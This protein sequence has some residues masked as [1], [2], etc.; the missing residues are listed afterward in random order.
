MGLAPRPRLQNSN[1]HYRSAARPW[2]SL[3]GLGLENGL[4]PPLRRIGSHGGRKQRSGDKP[5][6]RPSRT[7]AENRAP[8]RRHRRRPVRVCDGLA[9]RNAIPEVSTLAANVTFDAY[10]RLSPRP[11]GDAPVRVV[12]IDEASLAAF[13]QWP[14]PRTRIAAMVERLAGLG[15]AA[16]AF[17][18]LFVEPDQTSPLELVEALPVAS[19]KDRERLT[20]LVAPLPDHDQTLAKALEAAPTVLGFA[21]SATPN[22][23]RP[24]ARSGIAF[25]GTDPAVIVPAFVGAVPPLL[26][27]ENA[28]R[29]IG[30]VSLSRNDASGVVRRVPMLFSDGERTYPSLVAEALR[31][32]RA[33]P[34]S[35][36][37]A[38]GRAGRK[39]L[40]SPPSSISRSARSWRRSRA[41]ASV[42]RYDRDRPERYV[43]ARELLQPAGDA[44]HDAALRARIE[45]QIVFIGT[46]AAGLLD[47]RAT[48]L[49]ETVP[50]V[51]IHAQAA[52]QILR[53]GSSPPGLGGGA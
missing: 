30:S 40:A 52:E 28:A 13:G 9:V 11:Y 36:S 5:H 2:Y 38:R 47:L 6:T 27:L 20:S 35:S 29:G 50:G 37:G 26:V 43:S 22:T 25:A 8:R 45:G 51:S 48:P 23:R 34:R 18:V 33:P 49:G 44:V 42:G 19:E 41:T 39:M 12:D 4:K 17:D 46:S 16:I 21:L 7:A 14:W 32:A 53:A 3:G 10:Q 15:A 31:V 1:R 24:L